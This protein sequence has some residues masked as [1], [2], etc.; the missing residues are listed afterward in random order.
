MPFA[1]RH[2]PFEHGEWFDD[3][4]PADFIVE[5]IAQTRGWFYTMHVLSG[6]LFDRPAFSNVICHGVVLDHEGRKLSKKLRN[7]PDPED[8]MESHWIGCPAMAPDVL[9]DPARRGS[10]DLH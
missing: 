2:Y 6:A 1:Q 10:A 3:H 8:V 9:S 5:Y 4:S 7:Y